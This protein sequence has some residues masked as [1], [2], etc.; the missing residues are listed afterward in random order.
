MDPPCKYG[1]AWGRF[2]NNYIEH[3]ED[4]TLYTME[5]IE[6]YNTSGWGEAFV[7]I[8]LFGHFVQWLE[9]LDNIC[10]LRVIFFHLV[11]YFVQWL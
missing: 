9:L 1:H 10:K 8:N 7:D 5:A 11:G 3:L 2:S 4:L 6:K